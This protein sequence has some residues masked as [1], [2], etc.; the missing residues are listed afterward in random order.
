MDSSLKFLRPESVLSLRQ[1]SPTMGQ[2][3]AG[4]GEARCA[5]TWQAA[6]A[7]RR[8]Q[9]QVKVTAMFIVDIKRYLLPPG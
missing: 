7:P 5:V 8:V 4:R 3:F 6:T 2:V 1:P 9:G